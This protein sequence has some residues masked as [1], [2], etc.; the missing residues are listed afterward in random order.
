MI[1]QK[2]QLSIPLAPLHGPTVEQ[3]GYTKYAYVPERNV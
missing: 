2:T 1:E 3:S